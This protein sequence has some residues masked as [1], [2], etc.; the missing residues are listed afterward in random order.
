MCSSM[1]KRRTKAQ[2][3]GALCLWAWC[4]LGAALDTAHAARIV[5]LTPHATELVFAAGAGDQIVGTVESSDFPEAAK[6]IARVGDGL[7]TS[8]EQVIALEPDWVVGWPSPLLSQLKSF[9][10]NTFT[11]NPD[12]LEAIGQEVLNLG[13]TFGTEDQA[14]AWQAE[15]S[16]AVGELGQYNTLAPAPVRVVVLASADGQFA[17]GRHALINDTLARCGATNPFAQTQAAAPQI[18][19]ESLIA[20]KPDVMISGRPLEG[21]QPMTLAVP[22]AVIDADSLYRPGPRFINA[23]IEM[24]KLANAAHLKRTQKQDKQQDKQQDNR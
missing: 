24:C 11:S 17:I 8:V 13:K 5:T 9:G 21:L 20:A 12:S 4:A 23:A 3:L 6:S 22:L 19:A 2:A 7:N 14:Q 10:I 1:S 15:F 16:R 18:S